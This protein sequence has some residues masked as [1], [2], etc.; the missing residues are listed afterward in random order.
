MMGVRKGIESSS[1]LLMPLLVLLL[2][3][4]CVRSLTLP[5]ASEGLKFLL[6]P[7]FS[8]LSGNSILHAMGQAFFSLS[9]GMGCMITYG[10][11]IKRSEDLTS[12]AG[13]IAGADTFIALLAGIAIFPAAA[14]FNIEPGSGP[15][16]VFITLP[17]MFEK[18]AG[19]AIFSSLFFILLAIAA[20]T[21]AISLIEVVVAFCVEE[22]RIRRGPA[23]ALV[24]GCIFMLGTLCSLSLGLVP[25]LSLFGLNF[26]DLMDF[27]SS[28][29]LLPIGGFF[30]TIYVGWALK[31]RITVKELT[32]DGALKFTGL[33]VFYFLIKYIVPVAIFMVFIAEFFR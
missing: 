33:R 21:S 1:K 18:M 15:G 27:L 4:L 26:F 2:I 12:S 28:N 14:A 19:G 24:A 17:G 29:L 16:L 6:K 11:Y 13:L 30:I 7:D 8:K 32:S 25:E 22:M 9:I 5:G 10:S 31:K 23:T 20:L 3:I